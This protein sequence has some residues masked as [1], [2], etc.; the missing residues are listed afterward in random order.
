MLGKCVH[1]VSGIETKQL[2]KVDHYKGFDFYKLRKNADTDWTMI[3]F[4][5]DGHFFPISNNVDNIKNFLDNNSNFDMSAFIVS[6]FE[7]S[8]KTGANVSKGYAQYLGREQEAQEAVRRFRE[9]KEQEKAEREAE[10]AERERQRKIEHENAITA[11]EQ[12]YMKGKKVSS[13]MFLELCKRHNIT[14]PIRTK[15]WIKECLSEI[16]CNDDGRVQYR[17]SGNKSNSIADIARRLYD[18]ITGEQ[19]DNSSDT[20]TMD[21][22]NHLFGVNA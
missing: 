16:S 21:E 12:E 2:V 4:Y 10:E 6:E 7:E 17:Y 8:L 15:G 22:L 13:E 1:Y 19:D 9:R 5:H 14:V 18:T 3:Y 20:L 11:A